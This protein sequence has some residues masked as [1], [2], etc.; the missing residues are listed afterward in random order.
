MK[1]VPFL[2]LLVLLFA[3]GAESAVAQSLRISRR[4]LSVTG[5][6]TT[7]LFDSDAGLVRVTNISNS[8]VS[9]RAIRIPQNVISGTRNAF[10][11]GENCFPPSVDIS[12]APG[13]NLAPNATDTTFYIQYYPAGNQGVSTVKYCFFNA[14]NESDSVC[15]LATITA[16]PSSI[17]NG[18][19][20]SR[21]VATTN[22]N[23]SIL[24][25][26][27]PSFSGSG[28]MQI[29]D[30]LGR[31]IS[32]HAIASWVYQSTIDISH[33]NNGQYFVRLLVDGKSQGVSRFVVK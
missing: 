21:L 10:C 16:G 3:I 9:V 29:V 1:Y 33:L 27:L 11:W 32:S 17:K 5:S 7:S 12:P 13:Q 31:V 6:H 25:V 22:G 23:S 28:Q 15:M 20:L 19:P 2:F 30:L 18:V 4:S 14:D 24:N 26:Y 8:P